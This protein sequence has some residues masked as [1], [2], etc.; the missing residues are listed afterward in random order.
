MPFCGYDP[1]MG[2]AIAAFAQGLSRSMARKANEGDISLP[3]QL[4]GE[5]IE[6]SALS[7]Q[8]GALRSSTRGQSDAVDALE[9]LVSIIRFLMQPKVSGYPARADFEA[10]VIERAQ[11]FDRM[12][13]EFEAMFYSRPIS[14]ALDERLSMSIEAALNLA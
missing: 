3:T 6:L 13:Q 1:L 11:L 9:G 5:D 8:L 10:Q 14:E 7:A 12:M 2:E 4:A